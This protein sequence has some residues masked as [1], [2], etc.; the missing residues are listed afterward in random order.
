MTDTILGPVLLGLLVCALFSCATGPRVSV[1]GTL[2]HSSDLGWTAGQDVTEQFG[3]VFTDRIIKPGDGLVLDH[4]YRISGTHELPD[5]ITIS[6]TKGA[7]F[8]VTDATPDRNATFLVLG[9]RNLL[10]NLTITYLDT[11]KPGPEAGTNPTRGEHFY[12]LVGIRASDVSDVRIEN[13]RFVGSIGHHIRLINCERPRIVGCQFI[14][15]YWTVYLMGDV[16]DAV[17][18]NCVFEQCQGDGIKTGRGPN[19][20][21][22]AVVEN[23]VFQDCGRDGIDTTGGWKDSVV[24][25]CI[26][27][28][29]F[30]G[31]DIKSYYERLEH[32][33]SGVSNTR[34]L[35]EDCR[36]TDM[37]NCITF[38][39]IDRGVKDHGKHFLTA[40]TAP[41]Y[42][43]HD[44]DIVD[45]IFERTGEA[46]V[47]MLLMKGGHTI[48]YRNARFLGEGV[49][50]VRYINV[51]EGFG[52]GTMS[53]EAADALNYGVTGTLGQS[54]TAGQPGETSVP[55]DYGP[56]G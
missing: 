47:T 56:R 19:G 52:P 40:R 8:E 30:S 18:R 5:D 29:L 11:P 22:R 14:G 41:R 55:F 34:I 50:T 53:K 27:R 6:A 16:N 49:Q 35:I 33:R 42:A 43:P 15:G 38:S 9:D 4:T 7:G 24:R 23:C 26:F 17:F 32:V 25:N 2:H 1:R 28:R 13:C 45:C 39:T 44:V 36:F 21:Q 54:G 20:T 3:S 48:R 10:H 37:K 51:F 31:M 46:P 12:P